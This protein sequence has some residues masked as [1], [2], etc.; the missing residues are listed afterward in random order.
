MPSPKHAP[1]SGWPPGRPQARLTAACMQQNPAPVSVFRLRFIDVARALAILLMLEGHFVDVTLANEWRVAGH[2]VY[3]LWLHVR[4]LAAP[5]FFTVTG[6]IF[7]YLLR[8]AQEPS[9]FRIKRVQRGLLR[10]AELM[11]W[12]Y[13]LQIDIRLLPDL[14]RGHAHSWLAAFH[15]LQCIA[16]GLLLMVLLHGIGRR[17]GPQVLAALFVACGLGLS[18]ASILLANHHGFLPATAPAWLQNA[19]KG[20]ISTFPVAPWL[21]FTLYGAAIGVLLRI[22]GRLPPGLPSPKWFL[23]MGGLL[24]CIGWPLDRALGRFLL[25]LAGHEPDSWILLDAFHG[26]IG[27][28]LLILGM[29][30]WIENRTRANL[31]WLQTIGRNTFPIY[32]GHVIVLYGGLFGIGLNSWLGR[33]LNPWQAAA[34]ALCFC[35]LFGFAAQWVEPITLRCRLWWQARNRRNQP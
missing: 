23:I 29:L 16:V 1:D 21:G 22:P 25:G 7:S 9:Y 19:I 35:A 11:F 26:R 5:M 33:S 18:V 24:A 14:L 13:L 32:V 15:V 31:G 8:G 3:D 34:G 17:A 2:P 12:G 30:V 28:I 20:P 10:A 27:Q 4:G 6:V